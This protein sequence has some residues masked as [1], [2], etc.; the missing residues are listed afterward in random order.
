MKKT[1]KNI[2]PKLNKIS[3][4]NKKY[5]YKL[6]F[7]AKK[8]RLALDE[9]IKTE[10]KRLGKRKSAISK[11][12]RLNILRIYR[13]YSNPNDCIKISNDMKY[14]DRKYN[15]GKTKNICSL[16]KTKKK[17]KKSKLTR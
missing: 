8:R 6:K 11:K 17:L 5:K 2:L 16:K 14:I 3:D 13:R 4:K 1:K 10:S 7:S 12:K 9:G 15:L